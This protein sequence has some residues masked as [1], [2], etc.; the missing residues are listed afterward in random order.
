[1]SN[2]WA[3]LVLFQRLTRDRWVVGICVAFDIVLSRTVG[4]GVLPRLTSAPRDWVAAGCRIE[5]LRSGSAS[6][7]PEIV[8]D[9]EKRSSCQLQL[10]GT[11]CGA[12]QS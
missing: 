2:S 11:F 5:A 8:V 3:G 12:V 10:L 4:C 1:M 9:T 6:H 7:A